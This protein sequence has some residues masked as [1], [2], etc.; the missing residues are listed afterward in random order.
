MS[1]VGLLV[2][3]TSIWVL[4][5]GRLSAANVISGLVVAL[6]LIAVLPD[7]RRPTHLPV[8]RPL[9]LVLLG[10]YLL[11]QL[12]VSNL[13]LLREVLAPRS[14]IST[15]VVAVPLTG[16]SDELLT[17]MANFMALAPGSIPVEVTRDPAVIYVHVLH[18]GSVEE[19]RRQLWRLRD[20]T[21]AALGTEPNA[22]ADPGSRGER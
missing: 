22:A 17:L 21:V 11:R 3:L 20:L 9:A 7:L 15:G 1:S 14:R 13:V 6:V 10:A 2:I 19:V 12:V 5:W 16:C 8:L 4:L 18:L